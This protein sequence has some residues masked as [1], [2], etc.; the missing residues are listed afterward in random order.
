MEEVDTYH[1]SSCEILQI[2]P[3]CVPWWVRDPGPGALCWVEGVKISVLGL[4]TNTH[5]NTHTD[6]TY[7]ETY[8]V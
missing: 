1:V 8:R 6:I 4:H 2:L 3:L 5:I 7:H